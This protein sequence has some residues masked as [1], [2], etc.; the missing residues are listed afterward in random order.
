M[1]T[2][3]RA[4]AISLAILAVAASAVTAAPQRGRGGGGA[5]AISRG[6]GGPPA[7]MS[8]PSIGR[9]AGP[10]HFGA[11]GRFT[12]PAGSARAAH[13]V[14]R[15]SQRSLAV[16][17]FNSRHIRGVNR[18]FSATRSS[19]RLSARDF[20]SRR[21]AERAEARAA[22]ISARRDAAAAQSLR[23]SAAAAPS[24][25]GSIG[26]GFAAQQTMHAGW[27]RNWRRHHRGFG[28][29]GPLFWPYAYD[30]IF[31]NVFWPYAYDY[32][33]F[34]DY[35]YG[36]IYTAMFYPYTY[37]ELVDL[38]IPLRRGPSN[39]VAPSGSPGARAMQRLAPL[40]GDDSREV[41][42]VPI[43][44]IQTFVAPNDAQRAALDDLGNAAIK[45]AQIVKDACP[46]DIALTPTGRLAA[47]QRRI[48]A[49]IEAVAAVRVPL[50]K[51]YEM[52]S[53]EQ[54]ARFD[55]IGQRPGA[56]AAMAVAAV[57]D[58]KMQCNRSDAMADSADRTRCAANAATARCVQ[59]AQARRRWRGGFAEIVVPD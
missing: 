50:E 8:R 1:T 24:A 57:A 30:S 22:R 18:A 52:L 11:P 28:W 47:M 3:L 51:F 41:A 4:L 48:E 35:G 5:P 59:C 6:G 46:S 15:A 39:A 45:A 17:S 2:K 14:G 34:W 20:R 27:Y 49:M 53:D 58:G 31:G 36:D 32:D 33:P 10:R 21:T 26:R 44:D 42:G 7:G 56:T 55:A 37:G 16:R 23:R 43:D 19:T 13:I 9:V 29:F 25:T 54:K 12:A 40:C 38:P